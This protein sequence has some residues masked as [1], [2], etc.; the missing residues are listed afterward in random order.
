MNNQEIIDNNKLIAIFMNNYQK[1]SND[2]QFGKFHISW[3]WLM[4]VID[5]IQKLE[6]KDINDTVSSAALYSRVIWI[7]NTFSPDISISKTYIK[8]IEFIKWYNNEK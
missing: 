8:V 2:S 5:K 4:P 3:D 6:P 1:L 7:E